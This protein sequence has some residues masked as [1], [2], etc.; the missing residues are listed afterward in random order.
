METDSVQFSADATGLIKTLREG[1]ETWIEYKKSIISTAKASADFEKVEPRIL[2]VLKHINSA[3]EVSYITQKRIA[4]GWETVKVRVESAAEAMERALKK[5]AKVEA[6]ANAAREAALKKRIATENMYRL[7]FARLDAQAEA[8]A[9]AQ[10]KIELQKRLATEKMYASLFKQ[11]DDQE[12]RDMLAKQKDLLGRESRLREMR[13]ALPA[14][15]ERA[16]SRFFAAPASRYAPITRD[17]A[18]QQGLSYQTGTSTSIYG[19]PVPQPRQSL[20][21]RLN[22]T[23]T[24]ISGLARSVGS[25]T[26]NVGLYGS[27][28]AVGNQ[29]TESLSRNIEIARGIGEIRTISQDAQL[30]TEEWRKSVQGLSIAYG[31]DVKDQMG[32]VYELISNQ[33]AKGQDAIKFMES[34]NKFALATVSSTE[35]SVNLLSSILNAY[36]MDVSETENISAKLF[37]TIELGRVKAA[38]FSDTIGN[39]AIVASKVGVNLDELLGSVAT[40]TIQGEKYNHTAT[41]LRGIMLKLLNPTEE[42]KEFF[43]SLGVE[44]AKDAIELKGFAGLLQE[45]VTYTKDNS[46]AMHDLINRE[47]GL[48]AAFGLT[49]DKMELFIKNIE[50]MK[51]ASTSYGAAVTEMMD[52]VATKSDRTNAFLKSVMDNLTKGLVESWTDIV[53]YWAEP[54]MSLP[55]KVSTAL[56]KIDSESK[57]FIADQKKIYQGL[58]EIHN[59]VLVQQ[60]ANTR[61]SFN[62]MTEITMDAYETQRGMAGRIGS[63]IT[64]E[65]LN[66]ETESEKVFKRLKFNVDNLDQ[67]LSSLSATRAD[68]LAEMELRGGASG[69]KRIDIL[70]RQVESL[71]KV[72]AEALSRKDSSEIMRIGDKIVNV[73]REM[74]REQETILKNDDRVISKKEKNL[75]KIAGIEDRAERQRALLTYQRDAREIKRQADLETTL[76]K[77]KTPKGKV[78]DARLRSRVAST[79]AYDEQSLA[80]RL[81][82]LDEATLSKKESIREANEAL[83]VSDLT[84]VDYLEK[85]NQLLIEQETIQK[86]LAE[87]S[88][89]EAKKMQ[90]DII[91]RDLRKAELTQYLSEM[92]E[93]KL[94]KLKISDTEGLKSVL[95]DRRD[96]LRDIES[97]AKLLEV[98]ESYLTPIRESMAEEDR[99]IQS[100]ITH[101]EKL[102]E[103]QQRRKELEKEIVARQEETVA[104]AAADAQANAKKFQAYV[105][106]VNTQLKYGQRFGASLGA[107]PDLSVTADEQSLTKMRDFLKPIA[108]RQGRL[109]GLLTTEARAEVLEPLRLIQLALNTLGRDNTL[110]QNAKEATAILEQTADDFAALNINASAVDA[111]TLN[112]SEAYRANIKL[113]DENIKALERFNQNLRQSPLLTIPTPTNPLPI[114]TKAFGGMMRGNDYIPALLNPGETVINA[115]NTRRFHSQL[116]AMNAAPQ[117]V[118]NTTTFGN[119]NISMTATGNVNYDVASLGKA[120]KKMAKRGLI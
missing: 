92:R 111:S 16:Y 98:P 63:I 51:D 78:K 34:A 1:S 93:F 5:E 104:T 32:A 105:A 89:V 108:D 70:N 52:N 45:M 12:R 40:L 68:L 95:S 79:K 118:S 114:Q 9:N 75:K 91:A 44:T 76:S 80:H 56:D 33:V 21:Q 37:K 106:D 53:F 65:F 59:K 86:R 73:Y 85:A 110:Q 48:T 31:K 39:I 94:S 87:E 103:V 43:K 77:S 120:I 14:V 50:A 36:S 41:Q 30:T 55:S 101:E 26:A 3:G 49:G 61:K 23:G 97:S 8:K 38:E 54:W 84:R 62:K 13:S 24:G 60:E 69:Q 10:R 2:R 58:L 15:N 112:L 42:M 17:I 7:M 66:L 88:K 71:K 47:R 74:A 11:I 115:P 67:H 113:L 90:G 64:T 19:G 99:L 35:N 102:L 28:L 57:S 100:R 96:L 6:K 83:A 72:Q 109:Q 22:Y 81:V 116:V 20:A 29:I 117:N 27:V 46:N 82:A 25:A 4:D 107:L 119:I 18:L